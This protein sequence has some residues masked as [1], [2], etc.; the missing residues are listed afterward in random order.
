[1]DALV[2]EERGLGAKRRS[3]PCNWRTGPIY[4]VGGEGPYSREGSETM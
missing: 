1:M 2:A 3:D 4:K